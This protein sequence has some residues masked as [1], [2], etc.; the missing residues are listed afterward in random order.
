VRMLDLASFKG[1]GREVQGGTA[2]LIR[3]PLDP[4][5]R[6]ASLE[7]EVKLYGIVAALMAVTLMRS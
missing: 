1:M 5:R 4:G 2:N 3:M 6:L 7:I